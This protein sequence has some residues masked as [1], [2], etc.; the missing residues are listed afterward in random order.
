MNIVEQVA[1]II[2][3][4]GAYGVAYSDSACTQQIPF[5]TRQKYFQS[6]YEHLAVEIIKFIRRHDPQQVKDELIEF[7]KDGWRRLGVPIDDPSLRETADQ[8]I[9]EKYA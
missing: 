8:T 9:R 6:K 3:S 2:D 4:E 1:R 5:T 7:E